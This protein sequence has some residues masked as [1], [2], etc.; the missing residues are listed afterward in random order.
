MRVFSNTQEGSRYTMCNVWNSCNTRNTCNCGNNRASLCGALWNLL[1]GNC[2]TTNN[3]A[4]NTGAATNGCYCYCCRRCYVQNNDCCYNP[5]GFA[6]GGAVANNTTATGS[7]NG[8]LYYAYQYGLLPRN[9]GVCGNG[10]RGGC[11]CNGYGAY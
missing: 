11:G 3:T 6:T 2:I 10:T 8:D 4:N 7:T 5:C 9:G 1:L